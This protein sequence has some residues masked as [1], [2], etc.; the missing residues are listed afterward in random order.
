MAFQ[1]QKKEFSRSKR[2]VFSCVMVFIIFVFYFLLEVLWALNNYKRGPMQWQ[3]WYQ[4]NGFTNFRLRSD[5]DVHAETS[6]YA[7]SVKT[8]SLGFRGCE[9]SMIKPENTIR[10]ICIGGSTTFGSYVS[11]NAHTYPAVLDSLLSYEYDMIDIEVI[12]AGVPGYNTSNN[13]I[14]LLTHLVYFNPDIIIIYQGVNDLRDN[15][16]Y[17]ESISPYD[18]LSIPW[19]KNNLKMLWRSSLLVRLNSTIRYYIGRLHS[20][21][22]IEVKKNSELRDFEFTPRC[23]DVFRNNLIAMVKIC[24]L[25]SVEPIIITFPYSSE[26]R[27]NLQE[28]IMYGRMTGN[29]I[30]DGLDLMNKQINAINTS[31]YVNILH[32]GI[33]DDLNLWGD[34]CHLNDEGTVVLARNLSV[35]IIKII[36]KISKYKYKITKYSDERSAHVNDP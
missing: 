5:L 32:H 20:P 26:L 1:K 31:E 30:A 4:P 15:L 19:E 13:M 17:S 7:T 3:Y 18:I 36:D 16:K 14:Y 10:I 35:E 8:N 12:N 11:G 6:R 9:F 33:P 28:K 22:S 21:A 25:Y 23:F 29:E 2:L 24:R 27:N 34:Y